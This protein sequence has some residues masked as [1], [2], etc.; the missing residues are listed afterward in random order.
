MLGAVTAKTKRAHHSHK[1]AITHT[2]IRINILSHT[3]THTHINARTH[4]A[5]PSSRFLVDPDSLATENFASYMRL[6]LV[7]KDHGTEIRT[8]IKDQLVDRKVEYRKFGK[9]KY[10]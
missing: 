8:R 2:H 1:Q 3:H 7:S 6:P 9:R 10:N 5:Q 4:T